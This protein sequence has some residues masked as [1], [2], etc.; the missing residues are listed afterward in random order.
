LRRIVEVDT[1]VQVAG[2]EYFFLPS[3]AALAHLEGAR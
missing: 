1:F 3:M 2:G